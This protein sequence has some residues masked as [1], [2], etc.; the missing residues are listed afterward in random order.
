MGNSEANSLLHD[1]LVFNEQVVLQKGEF[2]IQDV[3]EI[4]PL[5]S[6]LIIMDPF[7][8][9]NLDHRLHFLYLF[10]ALSDLLMDGGDVA[11]LRPS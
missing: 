10:K 4:D 7:L 2:L 9:Q 3:I 5:G 1:D 6:I 11:L 8:N